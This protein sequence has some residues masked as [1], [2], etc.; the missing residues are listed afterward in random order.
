MLRS[1]DVLKQLTMNP[2][3]VSLQSN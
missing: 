3:L 1:N 2:Q